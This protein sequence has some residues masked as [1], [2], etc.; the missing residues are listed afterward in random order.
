MRKVGVKSA[1]YE[2]MSSS[3]FYKNDLFRG[4]SLADYYYDAIWKMINGG[5]K[6]G[7]KNNFGADDNYLSL[8]VCGGQR[9]RVAVR[10]VFACLM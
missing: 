3:F 5:C 2:C 7:Y 1:K 10:S 6:S 8:A 4:S 9:Q